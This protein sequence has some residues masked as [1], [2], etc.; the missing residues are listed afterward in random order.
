MTNS[1][2]LP[3]N[4]PTIK[5]IKAKLIK[6]KKLVPSQASEVSHLIP[7]LVGKLWSSVFYTEG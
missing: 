3:I 7:A 2:W 1:R 4:N 5:T 6:T